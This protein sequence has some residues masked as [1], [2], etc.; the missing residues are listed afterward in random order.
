MLLLQFYGVTYPDGSQYEVTRY[1]KELPMC[2]PLSSL[3]GKQ[4]IFRFFIYLPTLP[5]RYSDSV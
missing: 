5:V 4:W 3:V 2:H 1:V